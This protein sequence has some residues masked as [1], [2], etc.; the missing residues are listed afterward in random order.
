MTIRQIQIIAPTTLTGTPASY[1]LVPATNTYRIGRA[2]F[3]NNTG[4]PVSVS[5]YL[6]ASGAAGASNLILPPTNVANGTTY[7]SPEL[8]GLTMPA[9][10]K[11][12]AAGN[13]VIFYASGAAITS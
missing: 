5:A 7:I 12:Y 2:G 10:A 13:G 9:G 3:A 4:A 11:L 8:A 1:V 6:V